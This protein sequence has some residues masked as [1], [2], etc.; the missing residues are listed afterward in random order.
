MGSNDVEMEEEDPEEI[1]PELEYAPV[2][3]HS[4]GEEAQNLLQ[5]QLAQQQSPDHIQLMQQQEV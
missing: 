5:L 4:N 1:V 2:P 3:K